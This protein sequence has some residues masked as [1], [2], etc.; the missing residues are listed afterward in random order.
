MARPNSGNITAQLPQESAPVN[1]ESQQPPTSENNPPPL[2]DDPVHAGTPWPIAGKMSSNLF[3]I[4][5]DWP[6]P[7]STNTST[8]LTIKP[9]PPTIKMEPQDPNQPKPNS[10]ATKP[11]R[12][13]WGLKCPICENVEE[14]WDR[15]HQKQLQQSDAQQK[16]PPQ[17]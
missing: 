14:D 13:R 3:K 16:Y 12:C 9:N 8:N 4:R 7:P 6:V 10:T 17:G 2:E 11:E 5:K 1:P 15:E